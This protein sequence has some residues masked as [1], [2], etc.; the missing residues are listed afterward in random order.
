MTGRDKYRAGTRDKYKVDERGGSTGQANARRPARPRD[1]VLV[2]RSKDISFRGTSTT[3][4]SFR[5]TLTFCPSLSLSLYLS[6]WPITLFPSHSPLPCFPPASFL[7]LELQI[8][9]AINDEP[10]ACTEPSSEN[11]AT[12]YPQLIPVF[13]STSVCTR[14]LSRVLS[15]SRAHVF[16]GTRFFPLDRYD[17][18]AMRVLKRALTSMP[19]M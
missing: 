17:L 2:P 19:R 15:A 8:I 16:D 3:L 10:E 12:T 9:P 18:M 5:E 7:P 6:H 13:S 11:R 14:K 4:V 1:L